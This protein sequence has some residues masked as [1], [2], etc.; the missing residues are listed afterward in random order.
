MHSRLSDHIKNRSSNIL[1]QRAISKYG[2]SNF[3]VYIFELLPANEGLTSEELSVTL[4]KM[5]QKHLDCFKDKYNINPNAGKSRLGAKHSEATK[6]LFSELGMGKPTNATFSAEELAQR[7]VR[8]TGSNNPMYGKPV[9]ES[10]KKLISEFFSK[11]VYLYDANTFELICKY[12]KQKDPMEGLN[13]SPKTRIKYKDTGVV[14]R[15]KYIISSRVLGPR[16]T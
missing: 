10:N 7:S 3:S 9:T 6:E 14:F 11:S 8:A 1:L 5:E 13:I 4:I 12:A 15:D 16:D 2:L